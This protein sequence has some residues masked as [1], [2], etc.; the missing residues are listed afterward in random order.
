MNVETGTKAAQ[1]SEKEYMDEFFVVVH[2][3]IQLCTVPML[4]N[5]VRL[6]LLL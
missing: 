2:V 4:D 6:G 3:R 5:D 1:F